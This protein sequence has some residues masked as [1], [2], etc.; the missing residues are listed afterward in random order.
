VSIIAELFVELIVGDASFHGGI[1]IAGTNSQDFVHPR[2][3]NLMGNEYDYKCE[4]FELKAV[5]KSEFEAL[6]RK[7]VGPARHYRVERLSGHS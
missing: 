6:K 7:N 2:E 4:G 1:E 5:L 3:T